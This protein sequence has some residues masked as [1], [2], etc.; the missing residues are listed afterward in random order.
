MNAM[1]ETHDNVPANPRT[2]WA[3]QVLPIVVWWC[4]PIAIGFSTGL[5]HLSEHVAAIVWAVSF[6]RMATG[7]VL[8]AVR[9]HR[10]HCYISAPAFALGAVV[11][12]LLA[13]GLADF[14]PHALNN[15]VSITFVLALLSFA[16]ELIWKRY[17]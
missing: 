1:P 17:A 10:V 9:C 3:R 14:G 11:A 16:P 7:C 15:T 5:L 4:L 2:D 8:N 6:A 13:A 12:G